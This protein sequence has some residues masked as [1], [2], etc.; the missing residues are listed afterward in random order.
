MKIDVTEYVDHCVECKTSKR[1]NWT[2]Y[3][4]M[5]NV[6]SLEK[7]YLLSID[8][9]GPLPTG[10]GEVQKII[11]CMDVFTKFVHLFAVRSATTEK[12]IKKMKI[13]ME[14]FGASRNILSDNGSQFTSYKWLNFCKIR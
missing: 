1:R 13:W 10:R 2:P 8:Y 6:V 3:G 4:N 12:K 11:V 5:K 7:N 9:F 14:E